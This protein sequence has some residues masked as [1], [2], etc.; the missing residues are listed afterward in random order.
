[1]SED[2][3]A[4]EYWGSTEAQ[5]KEY[6]TPPPFYA[7][8]LAHTIRRLEPAT[9]LEMGC[10]AGR[11][12]QL[13]RG[14]VPG[15]SLRGFDINRASVEYGRTKWGLELEVADEGYLARQPED[16]ADV[17]FTVSVLDHLPAIEAAVRDLVRVTRRYYVAVEPHPEEQLEYLEV[18]KRDGRIRASVTTATPYSYLHDY[19]TILPAAGL[20]AR[21]DLPMPP[22]AANWGPLYRLTVWEKPGAPSPLTAW[23]QLRDE[24]MCSAVLATMKK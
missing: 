4:K 17:T 19:R 10:N 16:H 24:L 21:L 8:A 18:W 3:R 6:G 13:L 9:V 15:A 5:H 11:N 20:T 22:Y 14:L 7:A 2:A 1:V 23:D 12:L